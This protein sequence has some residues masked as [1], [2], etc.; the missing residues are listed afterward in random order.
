[1]CLSPLVRIIDYEGIKIPCG[2]CVECKK[3]RVSDWI[4]RLKN[5][6]ENSL[7]SYFVTLTF[8]TSN[9]PISK[10]GFMTL[11]YEVVRK[12]IKRLR[13]LNKSKIVYYVVGEYGDIRKRPH[14]HMLLF[15][16]EDVNN[17]TKEWRNVKSEQFEPLGE[18]CIMDVNKN[19]IAYTV[20]YLDKK[21]RIPMFKNDDREPEKAFMSKGIGKNFLK[22]NVIKYYRENLDKMYIKDGKYKRGLPRYYKK[23]IFR[24]EDKPLIMQYGE[25]RQSEKE[26]KVIEKYCKLR[27]TDDLDNLEEFKSNINELKYQKFYNNQKLRK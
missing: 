3:R 10:N 16:L 27:N 23:K 8:N 26:L 25:E 6:H 4:I 22:K 13:K 19:A 5:E 18:V 12:F 14:Y 11:D 2:K 21:K 24:G 9:V 15:N 1:M 7:S 17:I 20:K